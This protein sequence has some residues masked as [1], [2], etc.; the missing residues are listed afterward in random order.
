MMA[1]EMGPT[2][3]TSF[4][5][6]T[7]EINSTFNISPVESA[8]FEAL[9]KLLQRPWFS[10]AWTFQESYVAK[11]RIFHCGHFVIQGELLV[12]VFA[13]LQILREVTRES[14]YLDYTKWKGSRMLEGEGFFKSK[15]S[16][17]HSTFLDLLNLRRKS[18]CKDER[19]L[20]FALLG[21]TKDNYG[22]DPDYSLSNTFDRVCIDFT[23]RYIIRQRNLGIFGCVQSSPCQDLPSWVPDWRVQIDCRV[24]TNRSHRLY[25]STGSSTAVVYSSMND[26]E[27]VI[28]GVEL[29]QVLEISCT[30]RADIVSWIKKWLR[31]DENYPY[32]YT[33]ETV[34]TALA[35]TN[36][37][38]LTLFDPEN[39]DA[40]WDSTSIE[41]INHLSDVERGGR[42]T[43]FLMT[44]IERNWD[45][46]LF[47]TQN[48]R[49]GIASKSVQAGDVIALMLGGEVPLL[50]R[51]KEAANHK[52]KFIR[53]CYVHVFMDGEGLVE[54]RMK[55]E[56]EYDG[57]DR[58]WLYHL[59]EDPF[60]FRTQKFIIE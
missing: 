52:Y 37:A 43:A 26:N 18:G 41:K 7:E 57:K 54:S 10:R 12:K 45:S 46:R 47:V 4:R 35:R 13:T 49:L 16:D 19:D 15:P 17:Y 5:T 11:K 21:A 59:H 44:Q 6:N 51:S 40:R 24:F 1:E 42:Y 55:E 58:E 38:D 8:G 25:N 30:S 33:N 22:I 27:L 53:E 3:K 34:E 31:L 50:L 32:K 36:C 29:D 28:A 14:R 9:Q 39:S 23:M 60:I 2:F 20:I 48:G 56:P